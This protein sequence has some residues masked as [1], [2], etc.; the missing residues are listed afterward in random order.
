[1]TLHNTYWVGSDNRKNTSYTIYQAHHMTEGV[2]LGD[3][4]CSLS[5]LK[6][7]DDYVIIMIYHYT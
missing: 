3:E 2:V 4:S 6:W 7:G 5:Y 1:M